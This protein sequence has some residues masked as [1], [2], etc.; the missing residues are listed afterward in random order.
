MHYILDEHK[1]PVPESDFI[2]WAI[3][4]ETSSEACTVGNDYL[5]YG[6][7]Q[8]HIS[9]VFL[10]LAH[11]AADERQGIM[12]YETMVF[13]P[14]DVIK[15]LI[16]MSESETRSI[17]SQ[18]FGGFDI[19]KRYQTRQEAERGHQTMVQFVTVC[20]AKMALGEE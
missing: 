13:G 12:L 7:E 8:I 18:M 1:N 9:T 3:W 6:D 19:Q 5:P 11:V 20:L 10:A 15:K 4:F 16:E 14:D 2:K 17:I